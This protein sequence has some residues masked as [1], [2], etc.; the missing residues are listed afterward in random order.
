MWYTSSFKSSLKKVVL[1]SMWTTQHKNFVVF[2]LHFRWNWLSCVVR[3]HTWRND[4]RFKGIQEWYVG[5]VMHVMY[6]PCTWYGVVV[7]CGKG[8][9]VPWCLGVPKQKL[10]WERV[11]EVKF[12]YWT[13]YNFF[14]WSTSILLI[15]IMKQR[16]LWTCNCYWVLSIGIVVKLPVYYL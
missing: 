16:T 15:L 8:K 3:V 9:R 11:L 5:C 6:W 12:V 4:D 13:C 1:M 2:V 10:H 7:N 14:F